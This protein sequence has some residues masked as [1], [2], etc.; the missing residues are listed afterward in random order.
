MPDPIQVTTP[1]KLVLLGEYAVLAPGEPGIVLAV[2]PGLTA[3]WTAAAATTVAAP[4]LGIEAMPVTAAAEPL[5]FV[6]SAWLVLQEVYGDAVPTGSLVI[7]GQ[8]AMDGQKLG[9]GGSAAACVAAVTAWLKAMGEPARPEDV[10]RLAA[11]AHHRRQRNGSGI[12][13]AAAAYGG[14]GCYRSPGPA[15]LGRLSGRTILTEPLPV[16]VWL[17]VALPEGLSLSVGFTG[18]SAA[19]APAVTTVMA[20]AEARPDDWQTF[21]EASRHV[22]TMALGGLQAGLASQVHGA[23]RMARRILQGLGESTDLSIETGAL[24]DLAE[25]AEA[26]GG[27]GKLS[28]AGGGDCGIAL[29]AAAQLD[30]LHRRWSK[31]GIRPVPVHLAEPTGTLATV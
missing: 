7:E 23:V 29:T 30:D 2:W 21:L 18:A 25:A 28:G 19:T 24:A 1:G 27:S 14:L 10:Y 4:D 8:F 12:D 22:V 11:V 31:A 9:L 20:W 16:P 5:P 15:W 26:L 13:V 17:P 3:T 6:H